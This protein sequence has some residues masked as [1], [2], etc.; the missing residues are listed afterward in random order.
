VVISESGSWEDGQEV[1]L[2][3]SHDGD[4]ATA[5]CM[6]YEPDPSEGTQVSTQNRRKPEIPQVTLSSRKAAMLHWYDKFHGD[7]QVRLIQQEMER[8]QNLNGINSSGITKGA[9]FKRIAD[10]PEAYETVEKKI[11]NQFETST[12]LTTARRRAWFLGLSLP[13]ERKPERNHTN[14][15]NYLVG[16]NAAGRSIP[17]YRL[18]YGDYRGSSRQRREES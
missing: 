13:H 17:R 2:S 16:R 6:A 9:T 7:R 10:T 5:V 1:K 4:Y 8:G 3:I 18:G 14:G 15:W 12:S 11:P